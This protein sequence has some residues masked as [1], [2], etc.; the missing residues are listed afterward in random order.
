MEQNIV[1]SS[2]YKISLQNLDSRFA[3]HTAC[4]FSEFKM[5]L[6]YPLK[7]VMRIR[8]AS[9]ELPLVEY[10]F[11]EQY[12]N[13]TMGIRLNKSIKFL[14]TQSLIPGNY[15]PSQLV[16]VVETALQNVHSGFTVNL[17]TVTGL[18]TIRNTAI[19]FEFAGL[20]LNVDI[21][22]R[23]SDWGLGYNL[24]FRCKTVLS[25]RNDLDDSY[26][27]T[28][29][30]IMNTS[31]SQY[32][33]LQLDAPDPVVNLQHRV[34]KGAFIEAFAKIVLKDG[35]YTIGYDD[36]SNL[37]RKEYTFLAPTSVPSFRV[38]LLN[39]YGEP[40]NMHYTNWSVCLEITEITNSRTYLQ[41]QN[42][43]NRV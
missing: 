11:S 21:A 38:A 32:Y 40:I 19:P 16:G 26:Y 20:S 35:V 15:S 34:E 4:K 22:K 24:G 25:K 43:Y 30:A 28:A 27:I 33:L 29:E 1:D 3:D 17:D 13:L 42:T 10:A 37:L 36:N 7:N 39:P 6:A 23:C 18:V 2:K 9:I 8:L 5:S 41:L 14:Q 31:P 12:G